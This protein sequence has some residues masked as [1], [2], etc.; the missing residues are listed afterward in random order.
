MINSLQIKADNS[1]FLIITIIIAISIISLF[2][3][4]FIFQTI[5][6]VQTAQSLTNEQFINNEIAQI[7]ILLNAETTEQLQKSKISLQQLIDE[8]SQ[9]LIDY[10]NDPDK[11]DNKNKLKDIAK[12]IR[13]KIIKGRIR[14]L[15]KEIEKFKKLIEKIDKKLLETNGN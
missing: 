10:Q 13:D 6:T 11:F 5:P 12:D 7:E 9:K 2:L 3:F 14:K 4:H 1:K 15:E 8:H